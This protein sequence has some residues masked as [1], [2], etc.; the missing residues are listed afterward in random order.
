[1]RLDSYQ[2][3]HLASSLPRSDET[4]QVYNP[5]IVDGVPRLLFTDEEVGVMF[6]MSTSTVRNRYNPTSRWYDLHFPL[7]RSTD[8]SGKGRK[9]AVRWHW[10]DL[11]RYA[12][13]LP[14]VTSS[15]PLGRLA[16]SVKSRDIEAIL[17]KPFAL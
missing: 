2:Q 10:A 1:M 11:C 14:P 4:F 5:P 16:R 3:T 17:D 9:A 12:A 8:G 15:R 13:E 6:S 7:P